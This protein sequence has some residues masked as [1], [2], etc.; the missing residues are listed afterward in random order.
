MSRWGA[1]APSLAST[2]DT[3]TLATTG[4]LDTDI[5]VEMGVAMPGNAGGKQMVLAMSGHQ[6]TE[7]RPS[8]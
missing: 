1:S 7:L 2:R 4:R 6:A 8:R 5:D 3:T